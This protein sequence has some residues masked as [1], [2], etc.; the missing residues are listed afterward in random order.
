MKKLLNL[1]KVKDVSL[2]IKNATLIIQYYEDTQAFVYNAKKYLT[3]ITEVETAT[4]KIE[5]AYNCI[6]K[7]LEQN[8][9][10]VE[11]ELLE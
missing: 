10:F 9:S 11:I 5:K 4:T 2:S 1:E 8:K 3:S 6:K 7:A